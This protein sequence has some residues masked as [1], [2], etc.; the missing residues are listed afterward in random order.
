MQ[1]AE[2]HI[3]DAVVELELKIE[4]KID[5]NIKERIALREKIEISTVGFAEGYTAL[6]KRNTTWRDLVLSVLPSQKYPKGSW[7][8]Y[9]PPWCQTIN[10]CPS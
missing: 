5:L 3:V 9:I 1:E 2:R 4:R 7:F 8:K 10:D 6:E